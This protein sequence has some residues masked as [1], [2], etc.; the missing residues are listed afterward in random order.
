MPNTQTRETLSEGI[1]SI[2]AAFSNGKQALRR[3][4]FALATVA[5]MLGA[6][7]AQAA[8]FTDHE[9]SQISVAAG[10]VVQ[11]LGPKTLSE[12]FR[13]SFLLFMAPDGK[14]LTCTGPTQIAT[15][16]GK[17]IDAYN[18]IRLLLP[19][20]LQERGVRAVAEL[21]SPVAPAGLALN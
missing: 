13:R 18:T 10:Q 14:T 21:P 11:A 7:G 17:D 8:N 1:M 16:T 2:A 3:G 4:A 19:F 9:C 12:D 20:S 5:A 6:S 15:P